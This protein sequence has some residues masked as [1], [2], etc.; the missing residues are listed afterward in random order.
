[1][2]SR[3]MP[4]GSSRQRSLE[5]MQMSMNGREALRKFLF[6]A[7]AAAIGREGF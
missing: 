4:R 6:D 2:Q 5:E 1:M 7:K 3:L